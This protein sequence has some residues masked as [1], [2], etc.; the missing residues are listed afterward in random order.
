MLKQDRRLCALRGDVPE[1]P[2]VNGACVLQAGVKDDSPEL[3][4]RFP[5]P[6][7]SSTSRDKVRPALQTAVEIL[8][9]AML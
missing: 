9:M 3:M 6:L 4:E 5:G 8:C 7:T 2:F 1:Q